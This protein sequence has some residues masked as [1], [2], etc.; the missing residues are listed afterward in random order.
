MSVV[1]LPP[2][3]V[4][5]DWG[6]WGERTYGTPEEWKKAK[7]RYWASRWTLFRR[8]V[9]CRAGRSKDG[10]PLE[11]NHLT[12]FTTRIRKGWTP[13]W[14]LVPLCHRCHVVETRFTRWLRK[15]HVN[16]GEHFWA[17]L[18]LYAAVRAPIV[19]T[20]FLV[21]QFRP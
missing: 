16:Y 3:R 17:T 20:V 8:C 19:T 15:V 4:S 21:W 7:A 11:L 1:R 14:L 12:Y 9:I 5:S 2:A 18:I 6:E 10:R 13:K